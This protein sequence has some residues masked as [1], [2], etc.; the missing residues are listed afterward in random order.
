[1]T[2]RSPIF[3]HTNA[4]ISGLTT[5]RSYKSY[6]IIIK[7]FNALQDSNTSVCYLFNS[8]SRA[9]SLWLELVCVLYMTIVITLFFVFQNGMISVY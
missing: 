5:I 1:M 8:S 4:T 9:L 7:E 6:D 3:S 2:G